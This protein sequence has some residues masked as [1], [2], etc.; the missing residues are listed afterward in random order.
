M[1]TLTYLPEFWAKPESEAR[2]LPLSF[3]VRSLTDFV[4]DL[5]DELLLCPVC[6]LRCYLSRTSSLPFCPRSRFVSP[7]APSR[8][9]LKNALNFFIRNVIE[10]SYSSAGLS[11]PSVSSSS[12]VS[13]VSSSSSRPQ[14]S[15]C[16][17]GVRG[18]ASSWAFLHNASLSSVLEAATWSSAS[19]FTPFYL[20]ALGPVVA[21]GAVV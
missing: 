16:A 17:H 19:V 15:V 12:T 21:A 20:F 5:P 6:A 1:E 11:P 14:S 3:H 8:P 10:E 18:V 13:S 7:R 2:P 9:L 4:G